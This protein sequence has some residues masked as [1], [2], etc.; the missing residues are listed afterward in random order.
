LEHFL[1]RCASLEYEVELEKDVFSANFNSFE[2]KHN[3]E[4]SRPNSTLMV[5]SEEGFTPQGR[6]DPTMF[7]GISQMGLTKE[8]ITQ[9][10]AQDFTYDPIGGKTNKLIESTMA[11][12]ANVT[13]LSESHKELVEGS[14]Q[15][16]LQTLSML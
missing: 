10:K 8:Y 13:E 12:A 2:V 15:L 5:S 9:F 1:N 4:N 16:L 3:P 14:P 11:L 6:Q 7:G